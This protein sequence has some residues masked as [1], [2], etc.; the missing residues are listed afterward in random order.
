GCFFERDL[1][2]VDTATAKAALA[3][4]QIIT[5]EPHEALVEPRRQLLGGDR[6][7]EALAPLAQRLGII[8]A[9]PAHVA[10]DQPA[11]L[12]KG[13]KPALRILA[14]AGEYIGLDEVAACR[15]ALEQR[16]VDQYILDRRLAAGAQ[17]PRDRVEIGGP[18]G[19]A[20]RLD[21]LD[22]GDRVIG[23]LRIAIIA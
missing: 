20:D 9:E 10:P 22:A 15:I 7:V 19:L 1:R 2:D 6:R 3:I 23:P 21:H 4:L 12:G 8:A 18:I 17:Q 11:R 5:P 14:P 16:V 13:A